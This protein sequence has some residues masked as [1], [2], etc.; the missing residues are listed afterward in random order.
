M[1]RRLGIWC[2]VG[3]ALLGGIV[4]SAETLRIV[5]IVTDTEVLVSFELA[6]GYTEEL[7]EAISSGL[8]TSF[9]YDIELRMPVAGW[10]D[11]TITTAV[12]TTSSQYDNLTR[13]YTLSRSIDGRVVEAIVTDN[14]D[15][16]R[17]WLTTLKRVPLYPA[18]R[19]DASRDYFVRIRARRRPTAGSLFGWASSVTGQAR[20]TFIP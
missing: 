6:D 14:D 9:T 15:T 8:R 17:E 2:V 18:S 10:V 4:Y 3:V 12:V 19:L 16:V 20:F 11:R 5:P 7:R 13:R 1:I